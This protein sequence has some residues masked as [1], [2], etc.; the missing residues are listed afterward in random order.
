MSELIIVVDNK[1]VWGIEQA[2]GEV[3][4]KQSVGGF[5]KGG[6]IESVLVEGNRLFICTELR[7]CCF[8]VQTGK[9]EWATDLEGIAENKSLVTRDHPAVNRLMST[10]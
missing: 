10:E 5:F 7:L 4:W 9:E 8:N 3:A 2:T 6:K 1:R